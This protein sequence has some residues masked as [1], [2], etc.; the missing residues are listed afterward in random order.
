MRVTNWSELQLASNTSASVLKKKTSCGP[1]G[2][3]WHL[4][5]I[6]LLPRWRF[7]GQW[8]RRQGI[9][10]RADPAS[11]HDSSSSSSSSSVRVWKRAEMVEGIKKFRINYSE[12]LTKCCLPWPPLPGGLSPLKPEKLECLRQCEH[13]GKVGTGT[14]RSAAS[15]QCRLTDGSIQPAGPQH[16]NA[17]SKTTARSHERWWGRLPLLV[18][19]TSSVISFDST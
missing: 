8:Q 15:H 6:W 7:P 16:L 19:A 14:R 1:A 9:K 4:P 12:A 11:G 2:L 3:N 10:M 17:W 18:T 13:W 5:S